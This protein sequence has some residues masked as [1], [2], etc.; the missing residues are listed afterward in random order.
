MRARD[1]AKRLIYIGVFIKTLSEA[2]RLSFGKLP[3]GTLTLLPGTVS[4]RGAGDIGRRR[5]TL[6]QR[7]LGQAVPL[8]TARLPQTNN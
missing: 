4:V 3:R 7:C 8:Q 1:I 5:R 2:R 6:W